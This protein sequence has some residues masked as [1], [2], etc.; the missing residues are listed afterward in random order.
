MSHEPCRVEFA[1]NDTGCGVTYRGRVDPHTTSAVANGGHLPCVA[2]SCKIIP[3]APPI[4]PMSPSAIVLP[5]TRR[6]LGARKSPPSLFLVLGLKVVD[7][8]TEKKPF[9]SIE[10][11]LSPEVFVALETPASF[12]RGTGHKN[13]FRLKLKL[14]QLRNNCRESKAAQIVRS[15]TKMRS[16]D[17]SP[18]MSSPTVQPEPRSGNI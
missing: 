14:I 17:H 16:H 8:P 9:L 11:L 2:S 18:C 13:G 6:L 15:V 4:R 5:P 1:E 3:A 12:S 10:K 7:P